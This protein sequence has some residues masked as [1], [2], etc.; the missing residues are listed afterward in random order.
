MATKT[1]KA[2]KRFIL[3]LATVDLGAELG[4]RMKRCIEGDHELRHVTHHKR[5]APWLRKAIEALCDVQEKANG[6]GG[7]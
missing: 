2:E 1:A 5:R 3:N 6:K 7:K 4:E